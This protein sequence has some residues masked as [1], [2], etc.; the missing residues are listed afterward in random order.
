MAQQEKKNKKIS[1]ILGPELLFSRILQADKNPRT[2]QEN[3]GVYV[4][5]ITLL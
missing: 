5:V 3:Q 4:Q 2:I 1:R